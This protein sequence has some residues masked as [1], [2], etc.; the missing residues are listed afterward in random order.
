LIC[1]DTF[2]NHFHPEIG[3]AAVA[4]LEAAGYRV[5]VPAAHV[6][7]GRPLYDDGMLDR[8]ER[9]LPAVRNIPKDALIVADGFSCRSQIAH[10]TDR[11]GLHLAEVI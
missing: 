2:N 11:R 1:P 4:V 5:V 6:C 9:R 8:V 7:C 3:E 10:A